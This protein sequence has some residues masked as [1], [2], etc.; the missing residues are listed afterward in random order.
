MSKKNMLNTLRIDLF[1]MKQIDEMIDNVKTFE[2]K[3]ALK[4]IIFALK[5]LLQ[6]KIEEFEK[7]GC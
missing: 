6:L 1:N 2:V 4:V 7:K 5:H 3:P